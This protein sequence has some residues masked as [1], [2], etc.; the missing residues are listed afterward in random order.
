MTEEYYISLIIQ[1]LSEGISREQ[2]MALDKWLNLS[3]ENK[4]VKSKLVNSWKNADTYKVDTVVDENSA[5]A[6][7]SSKLPSKDITTPQTAKVKSIPFWRRPLSIA[8]S[9]LLLIGFSWVFLSEPSTQTVSY[10]TNAG[11]T[12]NITLPDGSLIDL[13]EN[14]Q[15]AYMDEGSTR[16]VKL[17]GEGLFNVSHDAEKPFIVETNNTT[18]TV[19][20]TKFN[21]NASSKELTE[22]SLF[23]GKVSFKAN[24]EHE[25]ILLPGDLVSYNKTLNQMQTKKFTNENAIAWKTKQ[26]NFENQALQDVINTIEKYFDK[27]IEINLNNNACVFTGSFPNPEYKEVIEVFEYTYDMSFTQNGDSDKIVIKN[28]K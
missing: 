26:L 4:A 20:G 2:E 11:E 15:L 25:T 27:K 17:S 8:A 14:S 12:I 21:I 28:C 19:L 9:L 7:I 1:Q 3:D 13:N 24:D 23:E 5:W 6:N 10:S 18:T 16:S 22:V